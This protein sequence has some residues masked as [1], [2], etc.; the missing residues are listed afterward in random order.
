M[1][2]KDVGQ[3]WVLAICSVLVQV[4]MCAGQECG[5][6]TLSFSPTCYG[7]QYQVTVN[8]VYDQC[9]CDGVAQQDCNGTFHLPAG[10]HLWS[11]WCD[12]QAHEVSLQVPAEPACSVQA[13]FSLMEAPTCFGCADGKAMFQGTTN[14]C[15]GYQDNWFGSI[16]AASGEQTTIYGLAAGTY[17]VN[18]VSLPGGC[19]ATAS[20]TVPLHECPVMFP[21]G[22]TVFQPTSD[23]SCSNG[24]IQFQP[25]TGPEWMLSVE[26]HDTT[27]QVGTTSSFAPLSD[28]IPGPYQLRAWKEAYDPLLQ[29]DRECEVW[30]TVYLG[31]P[32]CGDVAR[33]HPKVLLGGAYSSSSGLMTTALALGGLLPLTE[34]YTSMGYIHSSGGGGEATTAAVLSTTGSDGIVDWVVLELRDASDPSVVIATRSALIQSD[35]DVVDV[36]GVSPVRFEAPQGMYYLGVVHRNHLAVMSAMPVEFGETVAQPDLTLGGATYGTEATRMVG[37]VQVLWAGD[38]GADGNIQYTGSRND[39]DRILFAVGSTVP[40]TVIVGYKWE[41]VNLD[42]LIKYAGPNNDRDPILLSVGST[43]PNNVR[44]CQVPGAY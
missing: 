10:D 44:V 20:V 17:S 24:R 35:G 32:G 15:D 7:T 40:N 16:H 34:P 3:E 33:V 6:A 30:K 8:G 12:G 9:E 23:S 1:Q 41:D 11:F 5:S 26:R 25:T 31:S 21:V 29:A 19:Q 43:A 42:G 22:V 13:G 18:L 39:R 37:G 38:T 14:A 4:P 36:D 2:R 27:L 28:L